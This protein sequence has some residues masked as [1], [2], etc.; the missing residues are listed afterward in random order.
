VDTSVRRKSAGDHEIRE[1]DVD[2]VARPERQQD[3]LRRADRR[4]GGLVPDQ[5]VDGI[6][7]DDQ[8]ERDGV[9]SEGGEPPTG[10]PVVLAGV[11][12]RKEQPEQGYRSADSEGHPLPR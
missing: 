5:V 3:D 10:E 6:R 12:D 11:R 2:V 4:E 1:G 7:Q 9:Q 8:R